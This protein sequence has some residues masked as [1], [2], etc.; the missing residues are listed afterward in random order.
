MK[1]NTWHINVD[2]G[3]GLNNEASL[4]PF[5]SACNI[6]CGGHAGDKETMARVVDLALEHQVYIGAHPSFPDREHFGRKTMDLSPKAL[7]ENISQQLTSIINVVM[8]AKGTLHH[9]KPH[10]AL[11]NLAAKDETTAHILIE[12]IQNSTPNAKLFV[13]YQ[14]VIFEIATSEGI[15]VMVEAFADRRYHNDLS[16]VSRSHPKA[17]ILEP[18]AVF[19]QLLQM[20]TQR[21]VTSLE[22]E[23]K[24]IVADTYCIH[25]DHPN[26]TSIMEYIS[27]KSNELGIQIVKA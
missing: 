25:G 23:T 17:I 21:T 24:E 5:I 2:M 14:S 8:E 7:S 22:N 6:A 11:Y 4:M 10:G 15:D 20:T 18:E 16:L 1:Q 3:E 19:A 9:V 26:A 12:A 13:P 27:A